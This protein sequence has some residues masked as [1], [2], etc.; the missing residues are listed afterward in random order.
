[1]KNV[2]QDE[3]PMSPDGKENYICTC[4]K[5]IPEDHNLAKKHYYPSQMNSQK[6]FMLVW[7]WG[8]EP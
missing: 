1:M 4:N 2:L 3:K 6:L 5:V 7:S 8:T